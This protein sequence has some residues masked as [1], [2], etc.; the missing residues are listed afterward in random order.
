M[1]DRNYQKYKLQKSDKKRSSVQ[2][3]MSD[4]FRGGWWRDTVY[5]TKGTFKGLEKQKEDNPLWKH[6]ELHHPG[7]DHPQF[8]FQSEKF[9]SPTTMKK[10]IFEGF[11]INHSLSTPGHLMNSKTEYK[12]GE[13]AMVV[14]VRG[15]GQ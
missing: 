1:Q 5:K 3:P 12:Q 13:V 4:L 7:Q 15:L 9:F 6:T 8:Q 2:L 10:A 11:S 14:L